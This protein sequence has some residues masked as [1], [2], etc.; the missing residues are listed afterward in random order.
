M[1]EEIELDMSPMYEGERIRK[2]DIWVEMGGPKADAFELSVAGT[3]DEVQD[4]KVTVVGPDISEMEEGKT[5]PFGMIF[6]V[7]GELI[8]KDL[9]SIIERRNHALLS[10]IHGWMHLNQRDAIW[11]RAGLDL[12][13]AGVTSFEQIFKN[14]MNLYKAE[15]PFIEKMEVT[16]ITDPAAVAKGLEQAHAAYHARDE[17]A[18]GLHD[19]E[20]DVFYGCTL[21]QAFAPTS[22]CAVTPDRPSLCGAITWFDGRA[23]AKVDP[24]GPQFAIPKGAV[25]DE[26]AGEYESVNE[27]AAARSGGEYSRMALYT[28]FDAPHTSCGCFETIGFYMPEVDGIGIVDRDFRNPTPNGLPFSTMAG[29]AGGGKQVVGFLGM[30]LLY[31]FSPKFLQADGGWR[32]IVWMPKELKVRVKDGIDAEMYDKIAT[33]EDAPDLTALKKFLLKVDHPVVDGV[34]RKVDGKKVTEGWK[35]EDP[36]EYEDA[37]IAFIEETGGDIDVD[38]IKAKLNMSEGQFM[39]VIEYLQNEGILE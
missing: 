16:I 1:A 10:Y 31:Y 29:Q 5:I 18:K 20:V 24:E 8:E 15:M 25:I 39:Q 34:E 13:K 6:K 2:G 35:V 4:G 17:R 3:M 38:A 23:A 19:E 26:I 27:M 32:R 11:M 14:V 30:G 33:E 22:A 37:V 36:S 12:K 9:E 28:F 21:C 7:A